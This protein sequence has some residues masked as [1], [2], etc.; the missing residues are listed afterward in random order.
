M[1]FNDRMALGNRLADSLLGIRGTDSILVCLKPSSMMVAVAMAIKLRAWIFP[2][3]YESMIN[4]LDPT[5]K[6]GAIDQDGEFCLHPMITNNEFEYI[7]QEFMS[8]IE[9][10]KREAMSRL[11][12]TMNQYHGT[13]DPHIMNNRNIV[14]VGD[15]MMNSLELEIAKLIMKPLTPAAIYGTV[16]NVTA[17][18]S[19]QFHLD[20]NQSV[21][22]DVLPSAVFGEDHYFENQDAYSHEEKQSL[23]LNIAQYWT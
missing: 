11:N 17:D 3:F 20:T 8:Q 14:L 21:I 4:P 6:L 1:Y 13:T 7:H 19:D 9:E 5:K 12:Q 16:G 23:A 15:V 10:E 22:L 2:L 18:V